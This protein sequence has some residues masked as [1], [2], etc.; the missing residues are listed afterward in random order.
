[1]DHF[2]KKE[3]QKRILLTKQLLA[4]GFSIKKLS[5]YFGVG[6]GTVREY[7]RQIKE[8]ETPPESGI[9]L[10]QPETEKIDDTNTL[11]RFTADTVS[12]K[13]Y[14]KDARIQTARLRCPICQ[15]FINPELTKTIKNKKICINCFKTLD[16]KALDKLL[17]S[18]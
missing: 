16:A 5:E 11:N 13:D 17:N 2:Q 14:F 6:E 18:T 1:M 8:L 3:K 4:K 15:Q 7:T 9:V 10:K 12:T